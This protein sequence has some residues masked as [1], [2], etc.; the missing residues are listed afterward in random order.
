MTRRAALAPVGVLSLLLLAG[1]SSGKQDAAPSPSAPSVAPSGAAVYTLPTCQPAAFRPYAWP[2]PVP[3][4]LPRLPGAT[5]GPTRQTKDGLTVV[6][7][8]TETSLRAGILFIMDKLP[9]AGYQ[10][11]R[12]DAEQT[13]ADAPFNKGDV[14]GVLRGISSDFCRTE[15]L[16]AITKVR[17]GGTGTP[18]L[19]VRPG[20]SPS[21]LTFGNS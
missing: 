18:L 9:R 5:L 7:F 2:N 8:S 21:P 19:P 10:L 6:R 15:W 12:G 3:A 20:A 1:C 17:L 14:R 4:D 13:E 16:L 11:G